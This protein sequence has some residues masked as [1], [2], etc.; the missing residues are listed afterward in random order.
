MNTVHGKVS[1]NMLV[2][3][4]VALHVMLQTAQQQGKNNISTKTKGV[5]QRAPIKSSMFDV[6]LDTYIVVWE[7]DKKRRRLSPAK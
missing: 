6:H 2:M 3:I 5:K 1:E 4:A 7:K